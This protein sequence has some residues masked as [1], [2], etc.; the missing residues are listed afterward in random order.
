MDR[1]TKKFRSEIPHTFSLLQFGRSELLC[2]KRNLRLIIKRNRVEKITEIKFIPERSRL[3][4]N[5]KIEK[6]SEVIIKCHMK[7]WGYMASTWVEYYRN[8]T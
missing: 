2:I 1:D 5:R 7:L 3:F 6:G 8:I 4:L